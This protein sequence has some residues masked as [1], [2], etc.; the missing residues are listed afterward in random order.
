SCF[1]SEG[2]AA[3][4]G[5]VSAGTTATAWR[6]QDRIGTSSRSG[7]EQRSGSFF[8][9]VSPDRSG[10]TNFL[11]GATQVRAHA[12]DAVGGA[13]R[14][15]ALVADQM[16]DVVGL[17]GAVEA[18]RTQLAHYPVHVQ[19]AVVGECLLEMG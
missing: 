5:P 15:T 16:R 12:G 8:G 3:T 17:H 4:T 2:S 6:N 11:I 10:S 13:G 18:D 19:V 7:D 14:E 1:E 9:L